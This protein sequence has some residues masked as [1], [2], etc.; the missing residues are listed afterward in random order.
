MMNAHSLK[1]KK[2]KKKNK[3]LRLKGEEI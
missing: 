2:Q 1:E 3:F